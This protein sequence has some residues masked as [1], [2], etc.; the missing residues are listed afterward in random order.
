M[1]DLLQGTTVVLVGPLVL[2][3]DG[4][5]RTSGATLSTARIAISKNGA[6]PTAKASTHASVGS[7]L[8]KGDYRIFL[9]TV[10]SGTT[11]LFRIDFGDTKT[12]PAWSVYNIIPAQNDLS[13]A[14]VKAALTTA[15]EDYG[16]STHVPAD[17]AALV[18]TELSGFN[19]S[20]LST[21]NLDAAAAAAGSTLSTSDL[22]DAL[23]AYGASTL[24]TGNIDLALVT[25]GGTTL[26]ATD[27]LDAAALGFVSANGST[28]STA[29]IDAALTDYGGTTLGATEL[30]DAAQLGF[31]NANGSTL[32]TANIDAS[33][34]GV[35]GSTLS[36]ANIDLAIDAYGGSTHTATDVLVQAQAA[37]VA[38]NGSTLSA[39]DILTQCDAALVS[40]ENNLT[41]QINY[42]S[43]KKGSSFEFDIV[44]VQSTDHR[45]PS[46]GDTLTMLRSL[47]GTTWTAVSTG[48]AITDLGYGGYHVAL[49]TAETNANFSGSYRFTA[50][51]A[52]ARI[53]TLKITP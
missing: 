9:T 32:S 17:V 12:L 11:G 51:G 37:F 44:M 10:D 36:T 41:S 46:S 21:A 22:D 45:S 35:N 2:S 18:S 28:L 27:F 8:Y 48:S 4:F 20:T 43:I 53:V 3:T 30:A 16:P 31:V 52:D 13:A 49:D 6:L 50:A 42:N 26:G 15:L 34:V 19:V 39:T 1:P 14:E 24:S 29:N 25:H 40:V 7:T 38:E 47:D 5:T 33:F 23:T